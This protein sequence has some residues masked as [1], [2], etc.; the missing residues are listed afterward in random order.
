MINTFCEQF[1]Q[2]HDVHTPINVLWN[3]FKEMCLKCLDM[4]PSK[5]YKP[6]SE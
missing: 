6:G 1:L 3:I 2:E 4:I 5:P